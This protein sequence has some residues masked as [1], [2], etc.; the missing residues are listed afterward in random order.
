MSK[1]LEIKCP[2]GAT[3]LLTGE[4]VDNPKLLQ[5]VEEY[6]KT[7]HVEEFEEFD[8]FEKQPEMKKQ[9]SSKQRKIHKLKRIN[10]VLG[11]KRRRLIILAEGMFL[12]R[13][14][15]IFT[16][17]SYGCKVAEISEKI[18]KNSA[19]IQRLRTQIQQSKSLNTSEEKKIN[20]HS[21]CT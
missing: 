7:F 19:K 4:D 18:G 13:K 14:F 1:E 12:S 9:Y 8:L 15:N 11:Q 5:A 10:C 17:N 20:E 16:V 6:K 2:S 21:N 3:I